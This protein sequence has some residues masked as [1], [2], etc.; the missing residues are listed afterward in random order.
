[1]P[2]FLPE[3]GIDPPAT[4]RRP[5]ASELRE[6]IARARPGLS[7]EAPEHQ[8]AMVLLLLPSTGQ[9]VDRLVLRTGCPRPF[10]AQC[11]RRLFDNAW[12]TAGG[13]HTSWCV[14]ALA[15]EH[16][17]SDVDVA[18]GRRLR[19]VGEAGRP[20]WAAV[21][22]WVKEFE[23]RSARLEEGSNHNEYREIAP[24]NPEPVLVEEEDAETEPE[25]VAFAEIRT[26]PRRAV[27]PLAAAL[28]DSPRAAGWLGTP[29]PVP[30]EAAKP[31]A[32]LGLLVEGW[33]EANWLT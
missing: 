17:W 15:C 19:R 28:V 7:A 14:D 8:A 30:G 5:S 16:F 13:G 12:W 24:H 6:R 31:A 32:P 18:L 10:V 33:A 4:S 9:N 25:P 26:P 11:L 23:Y 21:G 22:G 1:M 2:S 20:E 27:A 29:T 3:A